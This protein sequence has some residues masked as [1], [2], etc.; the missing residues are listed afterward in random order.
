MADCCYDL[1]TPRYG[2]WLR[3]YPKMSSVQESLRQRQKVGDGNFDGG[4]T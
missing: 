2:F 3:A 4:E 1:Q